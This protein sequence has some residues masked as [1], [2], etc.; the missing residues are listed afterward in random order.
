MAEKQIV[1][2]VVMVGDAGVGQSTLLSYFK[3]EKF[4][5]IPTFTGEEVT[6][7]IERSVT[8]ENKE[9][10]LQVISL[11][12]PHEIAVDLRRYPLLC[13]GTYLFLVCYSVT[14]MVS[15]QETRD[16]IQRINNLGQR[17]VPEE[18]TPIILVGLRADEKEVI[19]ETDVFSVMDDPELR[20][21]GG[22]FKASCKTGQGM[23]EL[24]EAVTKRAVIHYH[25]AQAIT[26]PD[27]DAAD[28]ETQPKKSCCCSL[29]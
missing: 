16:W 17:V 20:I 10:K 12:H 26:K 25:K 11:R 14:N 22:V 18:L 27:T 5:D 24:C 19:T 3:D 9:Y 2:K 7:E 15:F 23:K 21:S 28:G 6:E 29:L 4:H 13:V 1:I 8:Y